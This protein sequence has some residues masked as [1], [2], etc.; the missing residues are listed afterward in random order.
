MNNKQIN[1]WR[2][3]MFRSQKGL[4]ST[5]CEGN[6]NPEHVSAMILRLET[7]RCLNPNTL[8]EAHQPKAV[9]HF[10]TQINLEKA[11]L[12]LLV[13]PLPL[14]Q[15][16]KGGLVHPEQRQEDVLRQVALPLSGN[17]IASFPHRSILQF[18]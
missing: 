18:S 2:Y 11:V 9:Q 13:V 1:S 17:H 4:T 10:R 6:Q 5:A 12:L 7:R 16:C 8:S 15:L 3:L 14:R